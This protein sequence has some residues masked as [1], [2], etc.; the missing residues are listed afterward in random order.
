MRLIRRPSWVSLA[1][2]AVLVVVAAAIATFSSPGW[3]ARRIAR[4]NVAA[5]GG[6]AAWRAVKSMAM[7]GQLDAGIR[8]D[9]VKLAMTYQAR[10]LPGAG[11]RRLV[12]LGMSPVEKPVQLPF[13]MELARP[14]RSRLEIQFQGQTAVQ[15]YD[16]KAGWKL[17]PFLGRLEIEPYND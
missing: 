12:G 2:V 8:R 16:G 7:S 10:N 5:R 6:L 4:R 1:S 3:A 14:N 9:P 17:R 13:R 15:V 11:K